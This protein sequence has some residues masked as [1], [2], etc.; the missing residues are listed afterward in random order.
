MGGIKLDT[1]TIPKK[2]KGKRFSAAALIVIATLSISGIFL[3]LGIADYMKL[4]NMQLTWDVI[5]KIADDT[6]DM[7]DMELVDEDGSKL[8]VSNDD[9]DKEKDLLLRFINF[10]GLKEVN[11]D[12]SGYIYIPNTKVDYPILKE[13]VP[14]IFYYQ[15]HNINKQSDV[16]GSIFELCD[17]QVGEN[18]PVDW[19]FGHHMSSGEMF[20]E[21]LKFEN[22]DFVDTPVYIYREDERTQYKVA[23]VCA[24]NKNDMVYDFGAYDRSDKELYQALI[25]HINANNEVTTDVE[26]TTDTDIVILSTCKGRHGS[27]TRCIVVCVPYYTYRVAND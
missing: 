16:Y 4:H 27:S 7:P 13:T 20:A 25:D 24:L 22:Q 9:S 23:A 5:L 26:L 15:T 19:L 3:C 12:V 1:K 17:E 14:N 21:I 6:D 10:E 11:P 8:I 2:I 18:S